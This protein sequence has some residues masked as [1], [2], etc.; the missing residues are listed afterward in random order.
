MKLIE[1]IISILIGLMSSACG[2]SLS[3]GSGTST[4]DV[5]EVSQM[6]IMLFA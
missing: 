3:S 2:A 6:E 5:T 4:S 1:I